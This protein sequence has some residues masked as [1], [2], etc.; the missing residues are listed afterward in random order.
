MSLKTTAAPCALLLAALSTTGWA[1]PALA[2]QASEPAVLDT[3]AVVST[4]A[5]RNPSPSS[6]TARTSPKHVAPVTN[7][8]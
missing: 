2:Q 6:H 7:P 4:P 3:V 1:S 8:A 5:G